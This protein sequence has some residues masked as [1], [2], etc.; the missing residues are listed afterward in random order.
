MKKRFLFP[1]IGLGALTGIGALGAMIGNSSINQCNNGVD[2]VCKEIAELHGADYSFADQITNPAYQGFL[3]I[4]ADKV[5]AN[6]AAEAKAAAEQKAKQKE[7]A[8]RIAALGEWDY[9]TFSDDATGKLAKTASL[10]SKNTMNFGFP[11]SGT[12]HGTFTI[13]NHP[14]FGVDA[15]LS[16]RQGQL[17]CSRYRNANV[18]VRF[19]NGAA[20]PYS[21]NEPAD[22]SSTTV[23]INNVA[24][25]EARM[26]TA[27]KMYVT[28]SVYQ[29][30]SRTWEFNV[31]NYD[32]SKV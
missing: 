29:E 9:S 18:L 11:Y 4:E 26:K 17:L 31:R 25:L 14:R 7:E 16:I 32:R 1:L 5:A 28:V 24:G 10:T 27:K 13:R 21:C 2:S 12:Q 8:E 30:G 15:Y 23:F 6:V 3:K 20:T 22:H 19:D